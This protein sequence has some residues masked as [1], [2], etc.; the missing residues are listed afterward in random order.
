MSADNL[1]D[2]FDAFDGKRVV[3]VGR[4]RELHFN[5]I[6]DGVVTIGGVV[7]ACWGNMF[8]SI[9]CGIDVARHGHVAGAIDVVPLASDSAVE[10]C[11]PVNGD[12]FVV[13]TE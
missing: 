12:S 3:I 5:T 10:C 8:E 13:T 7:W 9:K 1:L 4:V 2:A 6:L 11:V